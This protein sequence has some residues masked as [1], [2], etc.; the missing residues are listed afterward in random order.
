MALTR[1]TKSKFPCPVCLVPREGMCEGALGTLR[2]TETMKKI[3][4]QADGMESTS[5]EELLMQHGLRYV[6]V[7][8]IL[9]Y[10]PAIHPI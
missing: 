4:H 8:W 10:S 2:T 3:Y 5:Q 1:G 7:C 6:E 9:F